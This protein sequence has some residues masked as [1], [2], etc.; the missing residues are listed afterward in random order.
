MTVLLTLQSS[1][2]G[3]TQGF[4]MNIVAMQVYEAGGW[5]DCSHGLLAKACA[6]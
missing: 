4:E 2:S 6:T 1:A 3:C 5:E